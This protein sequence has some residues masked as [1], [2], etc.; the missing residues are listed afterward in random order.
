MKPIVRHIDRLSIQADDPRVVFPFFSEALG[1]PVTSPITRFDRYTSG[2]VSAGNVSLE[3]LQFAGQPPVS[4]L[5]DTPE[6]HLWG[7]SFLNAL[8]AADAVEELTQRAV[9]HN[10]PQTGRGRPPKH[11][12]PYFETATP[13]ANAPLMTQIGITGLIT[14]SSYSWDAFVQVSEFHHDIARRRK[15]EHAG[16]RA[17]K[18]GALGLLG[19]QEVVVGAT[20]LETKRDLWQSLLDP[21]EPYGDGFW[22]V[23][24]GPAIRL[25]EHFDDELVALV[26]RVRDL[27]AAETFLAERGLDDI[28]EDGNLCIAPD[29][30]FGLDLRLVGG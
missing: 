26:L 30:C 25:V 16:F 5:S 24:T 12:L 19:V 9:G 15:A 17:A 13:G 29:G 4:A 18:G 23:G 20:D 11:W 14:E 3:V 27:D 21:I 7:V 2:G 28:A 1:L 10:P 8:P 22:L 6:A